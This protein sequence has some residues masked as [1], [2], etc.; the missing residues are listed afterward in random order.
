VGSRFRREAWEFV[1]LPVR[2]GFA[3]DAQ[4]FRIVVIVGR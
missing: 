4:R 2:V 3:G 1:D